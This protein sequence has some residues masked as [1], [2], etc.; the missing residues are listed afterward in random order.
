MQNQNKK[1]TIERLIKIVNLVSCELNLKYFVKNSLLTNITLNIKI[2]ELKNPLSL[3]FSK[4]TEINCKK[5]DKINSV[6]VWGRLKKISS[7]NYKIYYNEEIKYFSKQ[8]F[9]IAHEYIHFIIDQI[10][11]SG[12]E[13]EG[14]TTLKQIKNNQYLNRSSQEYEYLIE[15]LASKL[16]VSD[17]KFE[18][19]I[20]N[21]EFSSQLIIRIAE[22][23]KLSFS[24]A[25]IRYYETI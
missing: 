12:L 6:K 2:E 5:F 23:F 22:E 25:E 8:L 19:F 9:T 10:L 7:S 15:S 21:K 24:A 14:L 20:E 17:D 3:D 4:I 16:I 1:L 13:I 18:K 11:E